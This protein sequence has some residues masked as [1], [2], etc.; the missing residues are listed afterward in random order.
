MFQDLSIGKKL[1][2]AFG[3]L[4]V[5]LLGVVGASYTSFERL[6]QAN[7]WD[8]HTYEV[9]VEVDGM[10]KAL[11][12][13]ETGKRGFVITGDERFLEPLNAGRTEF[14]RHYARA[15]E[16]SA[17]NPRQQERLRR[18]RDEEQRWYTENIEPLL[19]MR[20]KVLRGEVQFEEVVQ[21]VLRVKGKH[22]MDQM[23]DTVAEMRGEEMELLKKR[24]QTSQALETTM[25]NT[26]LVGGA[27]GTL[28]ALALALALAR[29]IVRPLNEALRITSLLAQGDL[30]V[31]VEARGSDETGRMLAGMKELVRSL[32]GMARVAEGIAAGDL[33]VRVTP[34]SENDT[35]G[36]SF[37]SMAQKLSTLINEV[38]SG[39]SALSAASSQ[40]SSTSQ[41]L[42]QGTSSQAASVEETSASLQQLSATINQ[43]AE[44]SRTM[45]QMALKGARDAEDSGRAVAETVQAMA[46]IAEK[47]SIIEEIAYQTNLLALNAAVEAARAGEHGKG[48]AVVATEVRKLAER[49]QKAAKEIGS[50]AGSSVKVA[51]RSGQ[52]LSDLVPSI[53]RTAELVQEVTGASKDQAVGVSQMTRAMEQ[54]DQVTQRNASAAEELASTA[55][56]L[57]SQALALQQLMAFFRV[58]ELDA[59]WQRALR[60]PE[61]RPAPRAVDQ[62]Q[63][64]LQLHGHLNGHANGQLGNGQLP[65]DYT[66]F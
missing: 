36:R 63:A 54:V 44:N 41:G 46:A 56:E 29:G 61:P 16:L 2:F 31:E 28:L 39:A 65:R 25:Y 18:L 38:R 8:K 10:M 48:F 42:S 62:D 19:E 59:G 30:A 20:R 50:L 40:V 9:I 11:V 64:P 60:R 55:E 23:R 47:I 22:A 32:R 17:D 58:D 7:W 35:L 27:V 5:I 66:R 1:A 4:I 12:D 34:R 15:R 14:A 3:S 53:R 51:E 26:L 33:T 21:E 57:A 6:S 43:N 52:L 45:E 13:I 37:S 49:S 24:E